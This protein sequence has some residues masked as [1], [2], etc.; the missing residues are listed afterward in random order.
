MAKR[1]NVAAMKWLL[2]HGADP[3]ALWAHWDADVTP[4]HLAILESHADVVSVLLASGA[5]PRIRDSKHDS[6]ALDWADFFKRRDIVR[7]LRDHGAKS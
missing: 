5:D 1:G 7:I 2:D 4:L 6:D 3:N